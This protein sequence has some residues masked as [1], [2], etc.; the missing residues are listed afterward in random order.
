ML[1]L[2][3]NYAAQAR[4]ASGLNILLGIWL[5]ASPW[6]FDYSGT[7]AVMNSVMIGILIAILAASR[8]ASLRDTASL[9]GVNLVLA[10]WTAASSW[11]FGYAQNVAGVRDNVIV[12][13][14]IA[15]LA[16][17]SGG[18]TIA[19]QRHPHDTPAH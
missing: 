9:S 3:R 11:L 15:A 6:V 12:G 2:T 5:I 7:P 14:V 10:V 4:I 13:I 18:A 1:T 19:D 8:L 17:W 16:V